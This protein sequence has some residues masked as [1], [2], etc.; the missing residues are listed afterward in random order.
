MY[1]FL[2]ANYRGRVL[3]HRGD[4]RTGRV[5]FWFGSGGSDQFD[6]LKEIGSSQVGSGSDQFTC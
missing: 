5:G 3:T 2:K 1:Y 4:N 6:S